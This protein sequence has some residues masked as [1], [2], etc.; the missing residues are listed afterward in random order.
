[1]KIILTTNIKKLGKIGDLVS[2]KPGYARNFLF[3]NN[4]ALRENKK[5]LEYYEKIKAKM[6]S[7][8]KLKLDEAKNLLNEIKKIKIVFEKEADDKNQLYGSISKKEILDFLDKNKIKYN[9]NSFNQGHGVNQENL[10]SF[11]DWLKDKY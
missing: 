6:L 5:N 10:K 8:E 9:Y 2:V 1:M 7:D 4:M 11:L 3:P